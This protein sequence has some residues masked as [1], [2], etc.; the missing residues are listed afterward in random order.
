MK[1]VSGALE[2]KQKRPWSVSLLDVDVSLK[3]VHSVHMCF[4][5]LE[6]GDDSFGA[7]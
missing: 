6:F 2:V 1:K 4:L 7:G 5:L 3:H